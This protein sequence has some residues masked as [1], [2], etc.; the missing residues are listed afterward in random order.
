MKRF[1]SLF[2]GT[3]LLL[4]LLLPGI[5][6]ATDSQEPT[7]AQRTPYN[8]QPYY[9]MVNRQM[10]TVTI[11]TVG[12][13]G[14]YSVPYKAM[15]C[16]TGRAGHATPTGTFA[17]TNLKKRWCF[18]LDGTY[19]QYST[20][21]RGS[22]LF[23]SICYNKPNPGALITE[24]Y[25]MLGDVA[26]LG[27]VRLQTEDAKWIYENCSAGTLVTVYESSNPGPLGKPERLVDTITPEMDNG[28][29][30]TDPD[31]ANP[32]NGWFEETGYFVQE[33]CVEEESLLLNAGTAYSLHADVT[34]LRT[35][36]SPVWSSSNPE[37]AAVD[38]TGRVLAFQAG[39]A[40]ITVSCGKAEDHVT[41]TVEGEGLPFK[42]ILPGT[43]Y[44]PHVRYAYEHGLFHGVGD[45]FFSPDTGVTRAQLSQ[46]L[47]ALTKSPVTDG[48]VRCP[49][50]ISESD[51]FFTPVRWSSSLGLFPDTGSDEFHPNGPLTREDVIYVLYQYV[52]KVSKLNGNPN[53]MLDG[54]IDADQVST[55]SYRAMCW[56]V[57]QGILSGTDDKLLLP[58]SPVS[59][60]QAAAILQQFSTKLNLSNFAM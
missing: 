55:S 37:I 2:S 21:F 28:W 43:W 51:W 48:R 19:G 22:Y 8:G 44:Y 10:N 52:T 58:Q 49:V 6:Y 33:V 45:G 18:M 25:N 24:E 32:W 26:S 14:C 57:E 7:T 46:I 3:I 13:D 17:T 42:D 5:T 47:Y 50:D 30:P 59:R 56:A 38:S 4:L 1:F 53:L 40:V 41:V 39:T 54:Y 27:C 35:P 36:P 11:Y 23:H 12:E 60:A 20:Q 34:S 9:I 31:P 16:S 15:I 29:D